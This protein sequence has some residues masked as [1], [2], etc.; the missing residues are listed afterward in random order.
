M[1]CFI[2]FIFFGGVGGG[3]GEKNLY[4]HVEIPCA[5]KRSYREG[6]CIKEIF[7][8]KAFSVLCRKC[9]EGFVL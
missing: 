4:S 3:G 9:L 5:T 7:V 8:V 1:K 6:P 2:Y